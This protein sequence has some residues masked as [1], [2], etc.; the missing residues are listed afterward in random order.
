MYIYFCEKLAWLKLL[1]SVDLC[2][3]IL[4]MEQAYTNDWRISCL[5]FLLVSLF[6]LFWRKHILSYCVA[7]C[8]KCVIL[9]SVEVMFSPL[10][11]LQAGI[12][13]TT[14]KVFMIVEI[15]CLLLFSMHA[16][17]Y[18][19]FNN[20]LSAILKFRTWPFIPCLQLF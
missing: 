19:Y 3:A 7:Q 1:V 16:C 14:F 15:W 20:L 11:V 2:T 17:L 4:L 6:T 9:L 13:N 5:S 12:T 18:C 8:W 10:L